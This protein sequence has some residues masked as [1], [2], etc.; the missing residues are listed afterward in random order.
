MPTTVAGVAVERYY[1]VYLATY[2]FS[3]TG[4]P[5][6]AVPCG[7]TATDLPVGIQIVGRRQREDLVLHAAAAYQ[8]ARPEHFVAPR[9]DLDQVLEISPDLVTTGMPI[10]SSA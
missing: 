7:F 10:G 3:V 4:L 9:I 1:D 5:I 2:A 8:A 6:A